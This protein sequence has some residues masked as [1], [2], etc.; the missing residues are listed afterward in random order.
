M[1]MS[2]QSADFLLA[3]FRDYFVPWC[4]IN[5]VFVLIASD[6]GMKLFYFRDLLIFLSICQ[7]LQHTQC[8]MQHHTCSS[9]PENR[10][11]LQNLHLKY[12]IAHSLTYHTIHQYQLSTPLKFSNLPSTPEIVESVPAKKSFY[13]GRI[14]EWG[15]VPL[16]S[17]LF[18][19]S[20]TF[21]SP[22]PPFQGI[23]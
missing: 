22:I 4:F 8:V 18:P 10:G 5:L 23:K 21:P 15:E 3:S 17:F 11:T 14:H 9:D 20:L 19:S 6:F 12:K 7:Q 2:Q 16:I 13:Q 1:Q